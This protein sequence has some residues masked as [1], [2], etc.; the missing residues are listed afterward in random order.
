MRRCM[1]WIILLLGLPHVA[2][3]DDET[4]PAAEQ[5]LP[6]GALETERTEAAVSADPPTLDLRIGSS[7]LPSLE[8]GAES[9]PAIA[10]EPADRYVDPDLPK[11]DRGLSFGFEIKP[12]SPIGRLARKDDL[13]DPNLAHQLERVIE[14]PA[15]GVRGRYRF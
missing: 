6:G 15:F 9:L 13:Q 11:S 7:N 4:R 10:A 1:W 5:L 12:R 2:A 3:A 8:T 14:R